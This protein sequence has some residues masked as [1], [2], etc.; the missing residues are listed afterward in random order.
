M[1][2]LC[3]YQI[4]L[5][6]RKNR[7]CPLC[8]SHTCVKLKMKL[9][10]SLFQ[11]REKSLGGWK[12]TLKSNQRRPDIDQNLPQITCVQPPPPLK[13]TGSWN[14]TVIALNIT[15]NPKLSPTF[16]EKKSMF[17]GSGTQTCLSPIT[18]CNEIFFL[19]PEHVFI[20]DT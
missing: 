17:N 16:Q 15:A 14:Y 20:N 8:K 18:L 11:C 3:R 1:I 10:F 7:L 2:K 5:L 13:K 4:Y 6:L 19:V 9:I 12:I